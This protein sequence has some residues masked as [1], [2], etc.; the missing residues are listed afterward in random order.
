MQYA[1]TASFIS[2]PGPLAPAN[3]HI[4]KHFVRRA[5]A[6][7]MAWSGERERELDELRR[8]LAESRS[9]WVP[10]IAANARPTPEGWRLGD[11]SGAAGNSLLIYRDPGH[12]THVDYNGEAWKGDDLAL[13]GKLCGLS[14]FKETIAYAADLVGLTTASANSAGN[15]G[16]APTKPPQAKADERKGWPVVMPVPAGTP[17][18]LPR[19]AQ[20]ERFEASYCYRNESGQALLYVLRY[21]KPDGDK[22]FQP[23][24]WRHPPGQREK[25]Q[26]APYA[27]PGKLPLYGLDRLRGATRVLLLEGEKAA[28]AAQQIPLA[29]GTAAVGFQGTGKVGRTDFAPLGGLP[30]VG[31]PDHDDAGHDAMRDALVAALKAGAASASMVRVPAGFPPG[32]DLADKWAGAPDEDQELTIRDLIFAA[33]PVEAE[34]ERAQ[35]NVAEAGPLGPEPP[36]H[37]GADMPADERDEGADVMPP[38]PK[39]FTV[40]FWI[41]RDLAE[42][43]RLLGDLLTTTSRVLLNGPTGIGKTSFGVGFGFAT[44]FGKGFLHWAARRPSR[45]LYLDGEMSAR[46]ARERI[47]QEVQRWG[48]QPANLWIINREDYPHM[49]PLNTEDGQK[50]VEWLI[51]QIGGVDLVEFDNMQ[52]LL[53]GSL[54]EDITWAPVL[55]WTRHLT[56]RRTGQ[57][58]LH[59]TGHDATKGYGDKSR[60]WQFDTVGLL[61]APEVPAPGRLIGFDLEFSKARERGPE[62]RADFEPASIWLDDDN[63]WRSSASPSKPRRTPSPKARTFFDALRDALAKHGTRR[64]ESAHRPSAT[65]QEWKEECSRRGLIDTAQADN[66]QRALLSKYRLEL[67]AC[68]WMACNGDLA[69]SRID[70]AAGQ[71]ATTQTGPRTTESEE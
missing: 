37:D 16:T 20:S 50:F 69:W 11:I 60:E 3:D 62:N 71:Q 6:H 30:V 9:G 23:Q 10:R 40:P 58:W 26:W 8:R 33:K 54:K 12:R 52:A 35:G 18:P 39:R 17:E 55:P 29:E 45:T 42:P 67:I 56:A 25:C 59:H 5:M 49:P 14:S 21:R 61:K 63:Q 27:P 1:T 41:N 22:R 34:R 70:V 43:D 24:T 68:D 4:R 36:P 65:M 51:D 46:L 7:D 64:P 44:G 13:I 53:T 32:W 2:T 38:D 31:W 66:K 57:L 28:D 15:G 47:R 48:G 19:P